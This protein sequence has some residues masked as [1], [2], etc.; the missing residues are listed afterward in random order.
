[1]HADDFGL[2]EA[3]NRGI[4]EAHENGI[5]TSASIMANGA[6]FEHAAGLAKTHPTLDIGVHLTLTE[7]EPL[8]R[9]PSAASLLDATN[10]LPPH[11]VQ[12]AARHL[13]RQ[14]SLAAVRAELD[15][16]IRR[17]LDAGIAVSHL[18][19]HQHVHVLPGIAKIVAELAAEHRIATVRYP[20]ERVRGYMLRDWRGARRVSE[21]IVLASVAAWSPLRKLRRIDEFVGFYFGGRLDETNLATVV[22][23]LPA[24]RTVELMCHPGQDDPA[25][26]YPHWQYS[27]AAERAALMSPRI[28]LQLAA[29]RV[30][31]IS[32]RDL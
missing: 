15:A 26:R 24:G 23:G 9:G 18:D 7:E 21:Q 1:V 32:Y 10:R 11:L 25:T 31:L 28:R 19:G 17:V 27:W 8:L 2:S 16:Q 5:L 12:F 6:A 13:R 30:Q 4:V 22:A 29:Q 20:A 14:I 3:V